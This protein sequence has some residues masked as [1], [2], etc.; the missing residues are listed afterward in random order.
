MLETFPLCLSPRR[1]PPTVE[2]VRKIFCF[3]MLTAFSAVAWSN[4]PVTVTPVNARHG[5]VVAA[6]PQAVE[7]GVSV[8]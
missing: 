1:N 5:M 8:L 4:V 3:L 7:A 2:G 6:H